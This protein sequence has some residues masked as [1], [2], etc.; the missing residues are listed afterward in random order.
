MGK[1]NPPPPGTQNVG[2]WVRHEFA[3]IIDMLAKQSKCS[4]SQ[5]LARLLLHAAYYGW[6]LPEP[7]RFD[8]GTLL[9]AKDESIPYVKAKPPKRPGRPKV[10]DILTDLPPPAHHPEQRV[11]EDA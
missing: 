3:A 5:Y 9:V 4:R 10:S 8:I 11:A 1:T 7:Q 6:E 2:V